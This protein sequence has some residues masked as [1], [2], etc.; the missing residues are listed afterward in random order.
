MGAALENPNKEETC[1]WAAVGVGEL[2]P[3]RTMGP[4]PPKCLGTATVAFLG[5]DAL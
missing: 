3:L 2:S 5:R 1:V 4:P